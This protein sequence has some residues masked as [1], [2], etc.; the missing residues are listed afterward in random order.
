LGGGLS[1]N[2]KTDHPGMPEDILPQK[3]ENFKTTT[4]F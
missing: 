1:I 3:P 2:K 4:L